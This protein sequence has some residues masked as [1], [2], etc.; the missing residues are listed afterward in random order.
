MAIIDIVVSNYDSEE[1]E[2]TTSIPQE[3]KVSPIPNQIQRTLENQ[4]SELHTISD[5]SNST[6]IEG[7]NIVVHAVKI[8]RQ[9]LVNNNLVFESFPSE[10]GM[11]VNGSSTR[12]QTG[13]T[14]GREAEV[15]ILLPS[16]VF[17]SNAGNG[18]FN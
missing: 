13:S 10:A 14:P 2:D 11:A 6:V 4:I 7:R 3:N 16:D 9:S 8:P 5:G 1:S 17:A 15:A 18:F 12:V